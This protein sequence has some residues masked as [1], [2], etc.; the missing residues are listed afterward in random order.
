M[1][2]PRVLYRD[3]HWLIVHKPPGLPTTSPAGGRACLHDWARRQLHHHAYVH[4]T[5]RLDSPVSG[6]VTFALSKAANAHLLHVR[7][8]GKHSRVYL[9]ITLS[10]R[11]RSACDWSWPISIDPNHPKT[12][13]AGPGKGERAAH[14]RCDAVIVAPHASLLRLLPRTGR[15][16]QLR[17]HAARAGAPLFGDTVYGAERRFALPSGRVVA[18]PRVMLHC[19]QVSFPSMDE[20]TMQTFAA[21]PDPDFV[22]VW[23]LLGGEE[24]A[25]QLSAASAALASG[26]SSPDD[27]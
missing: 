5:S 11:I 15:T 27:F 14:T 3:A 4:P 1:S 10:D 12:R 19:A 8:E 9:G 24:D 23:R 7:A 18:A 20:G 16:H 22:Q 25:L 26:P 6:V 17:V 2:E 21:A 13:I